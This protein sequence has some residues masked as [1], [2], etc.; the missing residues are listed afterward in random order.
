[1]QFFCKRKSK[2]VWSKMNKEKI[3]RLIDTELMKPADYKSIE[4]AKQNG[5]SVILDEVEKIVIPNDL[6]IEF[7]TKPD[8]KDYFLSLSKSKKKAILYRLTLSKRQ[9]TRQKRIKEITELAGQKP[10]KFR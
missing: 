6:E 5:S 7:E 9:E 3:K 1:M 8:S 10:K 2:S 4:I